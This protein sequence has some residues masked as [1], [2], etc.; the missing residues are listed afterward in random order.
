[1]AHR[2]A[3]DQGAGALGSPGDHSAEL[4]EST[5]LPRANPGVVSGASSMLRHVDAE[6]DNNLDALID[7]LAR[8]LR[9]VA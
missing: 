7:E 9:T 5:L 6:P 2:E 3:P 1:M 4:G 8:V